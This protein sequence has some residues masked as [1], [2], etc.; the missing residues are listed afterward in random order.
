MSMDLSSPFSTSSYHIPGSRST[1][2]VPSLR[3]F[4]TAYNDLQLD[5]QTFK[6][7]S[8]AMSR[9][10]MSVSP[11]FD[12]QPDVDDLP[13]LRTATHEDLIESRNPAYTHLRQQLQEAYHEIE[14]LRLLNTESFGRLTESY[15]KLAT[16]F[17]AIT[18]NR[19]SNNLPIG[20]TQARPL[21]PLPLAPLPPASLPLAP[22]ERT[23]YPRVEYW[24]KTSW[25]SRKDGRSAVTV[26]SS[27]FDTKELRAIWHFIQDDDGQLI[28][29]AT[30]GR[31]RQVARG[32]FMEMAARGVLPD[33]WDK[34]QWSTR[35]DFEC[36]L[37]RQF[38]V[39]RLCEN[40]WKVNEVA[41]QLFPGFKQN[42][43]LLFATATT[44]KVKPNS[45]A[46][47]LPAASKR[48]L[49]ELSGS[50]HSG[51]DNTKP[52]TLLPAKKGKRPAAQQ[53]RVP[54]RLAGACLNIPS[55]LGSS[56]S[57]DVS[58]QPDSESPAS[59][60]SSNS[61]LPA[62]EVPQDLN[63][64]STSS[65]SLSPEANPSLSP[66]NVLASAAVLSSTNALSSTTTT[67]SNSRS[68][69]SKSYSANSPASPTA[70]PIS[71][72]DSTAASSSASGTVLS[73]GLPAAPMSPSKERNSQSQKIS[74]TEDSSPLPST[75]ATTTNP[76]SDDIQ[77]H[78]SFV[79]QNTTSEQSPAQSNSEPNQ[80]S[81]QGIPSSSTP[82][83]T[84][85]AAMDLP[86]LTVKPSSKPSRIYKPSKMVSLK[87]II[88]QKW[89]EGN[90]TGKTS[91]FEAYYV[92][93]E[94]SAAV[95]QSISLQITNAGI[96]LPNKRSVR[97]K[98]LA[99]GK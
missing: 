80:D 20:D 70:A 77:H 67:S 65:S 60:L 47:D 48:K 51:D 99:T 14:R 82:L 62:A 88:G 96:T 87:N 83:A 28:S 95:M 94:K 57:S 12:V 58:L 23:Q 18:G 1:S 10:A 78:T 16:S 86:T 36:D 13:V 27:T 98:A 38:F 4:G 35:A 42:N 2:E 30:L 24:T 32:K 54:N 39:L 64:A 75:S 33:S 61:S 79:A 11:H 43:P 49:A 73:D 22:L 59:L 68:S 25:Q 91:E 8:S 40:N 6:N 93:L 19:P 37:E 97:T 21:V 52:E 41:K 90:P 85:L 26:T 29:E 46:S 63:A 71:A 55:A 66:L 45:V 53:R 81:T 74:D 56:V 50:G 76:A 69:S 17:C 34:I 7:R 92:E 44:V 89:K 72:L 5:Y 3:G 9:T 15:E 31:I 84:A